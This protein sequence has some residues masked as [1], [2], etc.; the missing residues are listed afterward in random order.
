MIGLIVA[1]I[2]YN[3]IVIGVVSVRYARHQLLVFL[4]KRRLSKVQVVT[5]ASVA[6]KT[7]ASCEDRGTLSIDQEPETARALLHFNEQVAV[8]SDTEADGFENAA[9]LIQIQEDDEIAAEVSRSRGSKKEELAHVDKDQLM[10]GLG[11]VDSGRNVAAGGL[12][13]LL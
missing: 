6:K 13:R 10:D 5:K 2:G 8:R 4:Y 3:A 9:A 11:N 1:L 7:I 12:S